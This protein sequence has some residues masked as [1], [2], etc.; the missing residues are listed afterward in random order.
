MATP[1]QVTAMPAIERVPGTMS[2]IRY[3]SATAKI[4]VRYNRLVTRVAAPRRISVCN[5]LTASIEAPITRNTM[6]ANSGHAQVTAK[7]STPQASGASTAPVTANC[8]S[9]AER[10][11]TRGQ[12]ARV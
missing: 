2:N 8:T 12:N 1:A 7:P 6:A 5:A 9:A 11:S 3:S 10:R 4:G